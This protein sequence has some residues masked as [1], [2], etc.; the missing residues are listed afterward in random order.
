MMSFD[1]VDYLTGISLTDPFAP[2]DDPMLRPEM[3]SCLAQDPSRACVP[4]VD[5]AHY[6]YLDSGGRGQICVYQRKEV[7][8]WAITR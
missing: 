3:E 6:C 5:G 1:S 2:L 8:A 7:R 4:P